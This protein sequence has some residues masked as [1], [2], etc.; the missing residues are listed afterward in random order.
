MSGPATPPPGLAGP[1]DAGRTCP[2]CRF[3][4]KT[5]V[6]THRCEACG[7]LHHADCWHDGG[8][9]AVLGCAA[10]GAPATAPTATLPL[11]AP[12][13]P[14]VPPPP[15]APAAVAP[16]G[17][18]D[19]RRRLLLGLG[20]GLAVVAAGAGGYALAH[21]GGSGAPAVT[22]APATTST[23]PEAP[24]PPDPQSSAMRDL[25]AVVAFSQA[26]RQAVRDGRY[27]DAISNREAA[28][29]RLDA[30]DGARGDVAVAL[31][32]LHGALEASLA[33]DRAYAAH[34]DPTASDALA[35]ERKRAFV[36]EWNGL[37]ARY[38]LATYTETE[39]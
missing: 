33:S 18:P 17:G 6:A 29:R 32:L 22:V 21:G 12:P 27:L 5:G 11:G 37:A 23:V 34:G 4:L 1:Q 35:T 26:G 10:A 36:A 13:P 24:P 31:R 30:I 20:I 8:G 19:G 9:C 2:Y 39:I 16:A 38:G 3:A 7:A 28:L 15:T 14:P 25:A